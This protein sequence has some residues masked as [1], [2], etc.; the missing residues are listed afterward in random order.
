M[1]N[2]LTKI[3]RNLNHIKSSITLKAAGRR[4]LGVCLAI[5][6]L[7]MFSLN[8]A[9]A[10]AI[11]K[12]RL[13]G[14]IIAAGVVKVD[15]L[16]AISGQTV[17][18][19]NSIYTARNSHATIIFGRLGRIELLSDTV[20]KLRFDEA[21]LTGTL[22]DGSMRVSIPAG[23]RMTVTTKDT[24]VVANDNQP[25]AFSVSIKEGRTIVTTQTGRVY[26]QAEGKTQEVAAGLSAA[27][28]SAG[29]SAD[30]SAQQSGRTQSFNGGRLAAVLIGIGSAITIAAIVF[31]GRDE[32]KEEPLDFGGCVIASGGP[33]PGC[34]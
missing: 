34:H 9:Q 29:I 3:R 13:Y 17:F 2:A 12:A 24:A 31:T 32:N 6:L 4:A 21:S 27:I 23:V 10:T 7:N 5:T 33:V 26:L 1:T 15:G 30:T 8:A 28:S 22:D 14:E 16:K 25:A 18:S 11:D 20:I 19:G